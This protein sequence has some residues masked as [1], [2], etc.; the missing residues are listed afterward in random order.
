MLSKAAE[1]NRARVL[2][3]GYYKSTTDQPKSESNATSD[4]VKQLYQFAG[5]T[6]ANIRSQIIRFTVAVISSVLLLI[7][8]G[9]AYLLLIVP[10][11]ISFEYLLL[12]ARSTSR[13]QA[14]ERDY[15]ALLLSL[16]SGVRTGLDPLVALME[17]RDMF[18]AG[19]EIHKELTQI[20]ELIDSGRSEEEVICSIGSTIRHPDLQLF[21]S[22][23]LLARKEGASLGVSLE[24]L[25]RVTRQRQSFRRK[26]RGAVALQKLSAIGISLC[27]VVIA[28]IQFLT[29]P[30]GVMTAWRHPVGSYLLWLGIL[31]IIIGLFWMLRMTRPK[32]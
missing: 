3:E 31:M 4:R 24:R 1:I 21:R 19:S 9:K 30:K 20:K 16:A 23:L 12:E 5:Y 32:Y 25:A 14:F 17:C 26:I 22:A 11:A 8:F 7:V 15:T 10:L 27:A 29:N 18:E 6:S 2:L 13:S 28:A